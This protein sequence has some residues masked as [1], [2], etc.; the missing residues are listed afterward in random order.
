MPTFH[1][2]TFA[3]DVT[4]PE[5]K[6]RPMIIVH[7]LTRLLRAGSEENTLATC[8]SQAAQGHRVIVMHGREFDASVRP[9]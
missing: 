9:H 8:R 3:C 6:A 2:A 7:V 5:N 1:L 4:P